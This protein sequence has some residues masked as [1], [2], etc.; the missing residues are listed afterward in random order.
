[1]NQQEISI[2]FE[3]IKENCNTIQDIINLEEDLKNE[4]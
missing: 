2:N 4:N 3:Y 1:M